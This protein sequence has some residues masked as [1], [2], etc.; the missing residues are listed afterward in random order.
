VAPTFVIGHG[1]I[2]GEAATKIRDHFAQGATLVHIVHTDPPFVGASK[3]PASGGAA[4]AAATKLRVEEDNCRAANVVFGVGPRLTSTAHGILRRVGSTATPV[5]ILPGLDDAICPDFRARPAPCV[6]TLGRLDDPSKGIGQFVDVM[7]AVEKDLLEP[8]ARWQLRGID[9][10]KAD[11]H[12]MELNHV[13]GIAI[14]APYSIDPRDLEGDLREASVM[15]MTSLE[16]GF[17]LVALEAIN[18]GTPVLVSASSG[19][20]QLLVRER[21]DDGVLDLHDPQQ[22]VD[23]WRRAV[24]AALHDRDRQAALARQRYDFIGSVTSWDTVARTI[25]D[26]VLAVRAA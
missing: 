22:R 4:A 26:A 13:S 6:L 1:H 16:E 20:G 19:I 8:N 5:E 7:R 25:L 10:D 21:S 3:A 12:Q 2:T 15:C 9:P 17:G 14:V 23:V 18:H 11:S 24:L